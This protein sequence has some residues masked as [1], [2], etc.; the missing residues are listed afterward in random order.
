MFII[1][2]VVTGTFVQLMILFSIVIIHELG[3]YLAAMHYKW[4]IH[5]VVL[6]VFGGVMKTDG[7]MNRPIKEDV[8][9]TI[10]GPLQHLYIYLLI[11]ICAYFEFLPEAII[12]QAYYYN[13][14]ILLFNLLP[15]FPLDGGKLVLYYLSSVLPFKKAHQW[16]Y[17][18]S[19]L[20]CFV[21]LGVQLILFSFTLSAFI[22][23]LFL[24]WEN[25][26]EWKNHSFI[27]M[28]FL[29]SRTGQMKEDCLTIPA[30]MRL[31][32]IFYLF[33]RNRTHSICVENNQRL[34]EAQCLSYYFGERKLNETIGE[35]LR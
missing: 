8:L 17:T 19:I 33:R 26:T 2:A 16:T 32:E 6:W 24:I 14:I 11:F 21:I 4:R 28:R 27:F 13:G 31:I 20:A 35:I 15:I 18:F 12:K 22:L 5:S 23:V 10:A 34:S 29:L 3:H 25:R 7:A 9:V 30:Q 1:L